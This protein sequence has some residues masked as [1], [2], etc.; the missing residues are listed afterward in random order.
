[1]TKRYVNENHLA[2]IREQPCLL[3]GMDCER[4]VIAHHLMRP[5]NGSRGMG[6]KANDRNALPLCDGHHLAL[7]AKGDEDAF[8]TMHTNN[9]GHGRNMAHAYWLRSPHYE[10]PE[11]T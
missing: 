6:L 4:A 9:P 3:Q 5:W 2:W 7:H 1:M 11:P 10:K 8:F